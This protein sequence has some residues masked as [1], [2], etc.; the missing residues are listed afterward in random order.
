M[1]KG[2]GD[3]LQIQKYA[4]QSQE[5]YLTLQSLKQVL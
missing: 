1:A 5:L 4:E 2:E 3:K